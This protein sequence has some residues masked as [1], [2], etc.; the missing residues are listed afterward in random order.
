[1]M[2]P[3]QVEQRQRFKQH[4]DLVQYSLDFDKTSNYF[5]KT[6]ILLK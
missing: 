2:L 5:H 6:Y 1:M 3:T 4:N